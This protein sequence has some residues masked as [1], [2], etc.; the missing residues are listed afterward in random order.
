MCC[1]SFWKTIVPFTIALMLGVLAASLFQ[2]IIYRGENQIAVKSSDKEVGSGSGI[3]SGSGYGGGGGY[4]VKT[5]TIPRAGTNPVQILSKPRPKYTDV[6]RQNVV[7]GIVRLRVTF[8]A[9]GQ[10]GSVVPVTTLPYGLTEEAIMAAKNIRF[11]PATVDGKA[12][13]VSKTVEYSFMLF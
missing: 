4:E 3:S 7:T 6:A 8:L 9:D 5:Q 1:R 2:K 13:T 10:I 12:V 11:Q